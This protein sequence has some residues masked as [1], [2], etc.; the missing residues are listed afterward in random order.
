MIVQDDGDDDWWRS[1][2]DDNDD[3]GDDDNDVTN[4]DNYADDGW[5]DDMVCGGDGAQI[6]SDLAVCSANLLWRF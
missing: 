6:Y 3:D 4:A 5:H 1:G 2:G